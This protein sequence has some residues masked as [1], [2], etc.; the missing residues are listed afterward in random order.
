M[1]SVVRGKDELAKDIVEDEDNDVGRAGAVVEVTGRGTHC[2][3]SRCSINSFASMSS[4]V[5]GFLRY[6]CL[7]DY[8]DISS[9]RLV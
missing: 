7:D 9:S 4:T 1:G 2:A 5:R 3:L 8:V 6:R